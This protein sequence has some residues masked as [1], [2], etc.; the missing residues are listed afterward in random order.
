[1][2][3]MTDAPDTR[4]PAPG[5]VADE[6]SLRDLYLVVRRAAPWILAAALAAAGATYLLLG[7]RPAT[8]VAE[9]TAVVARVPLEIGLGTGLRFRPEVDL[10]FDT[11]QTLAYAR[12]VLEAVLPAHEAHDVARLRDALTLE[13]VAGAPNQPAGLLAVVHRVRSGHPERAAEA[14]NAWAAATIATARGLLLE[15]LDAVETI[16]GEG[17]ADARATLRAAEGEVERFR[18]SSGIEALRAQLGAPLLGL[19]GSLDVG[20]LEVA[21]ALRANAAALGQREA[22]LELL[23]ARREGG[24]GALAVV[25]V[26]A[27]DAPLSLDGAIVSVEARVAALVGE[28]SVLEAAAARLQTERSA[29]VAALG[30]ATVVLADLER[31]AAVP[32]EIVATLGSIEPTV[33]YVAR[34]APSGARVLSEASVPSAPEPRP[35][36][37]PMLLAAFAVALV[38]LVAA[39]L[40]EAVRDPRAARRA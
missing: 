32:R 38:G 6:V 22:E 15:N 19:P 23:R 35:R 28:R 33:A 24:D 1:M 30:E 5:P 10:S 36:A 11:Y 12:G 39:L 40:A 26:D 18:A 17:L 3:A 25:L 20:L 34:L 37:A 29:A 8:Y 13:R 14:A 2:A 4:A 16:T 31:A 7:R 9:A 27:P 21:A